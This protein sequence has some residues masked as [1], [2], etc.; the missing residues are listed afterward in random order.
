MRAVASLVAVVALL[1]IPS[2]LAAHEGGAAAGLLSGLYHPISGLDHVLAMVA[3]GIWGAQ[4]GPP[5]I[6][7]LPVTFPMVM[8]FGGMLG[9]MGL[10]LPGVEIGIADRFLK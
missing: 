10:P 5:A 4:L 7:V 8:A 3:V 6:W 9:L 1:A 2:P